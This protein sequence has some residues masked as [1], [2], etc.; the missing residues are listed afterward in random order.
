MGYLRGSSGLRGDREGTRMDGAAGP[1]PRSGA[2]GAA[3]RG[4]PRDGAGSE[5]KTAIRTRIATAMEARLVLV[6]VLVLDLPRTL[7]GRGRGR[8]PLAA[9]AEDEDGRRRGMGRPREVL[10]GFRRI[11]A[12]ERLPVASPPRA[13]VHRARR[14][15]GVGRRV[16]GVLG[17]RNVH[18]LIWK[19]VTPTEPTSFLGQNSS[20]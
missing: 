8:G 12:R 13:A 20:V 15:P 4:R 10:L 3:A 18:A 16:S 14:A 11:A 7:S 6:L 1:A 19:L 5:A 2:V 17:Y 9:L